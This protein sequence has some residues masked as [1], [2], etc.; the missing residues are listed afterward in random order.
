MYKPNYENVEVDFMV[1][2][3]TICKGYEDLTRRQIGKKG[4][5]FLIGPFFCFL[6]RVKMILQSAAAAKAVALISLSCQMVLGSR[7]LYSLE[8]LIL[9]SPK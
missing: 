4:F 5:I 1:I 7:Q 2:F 8:S 9:I 3:W 6:S